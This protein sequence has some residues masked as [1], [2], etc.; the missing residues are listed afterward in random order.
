MQATAYVPARTTELG[1][2]FQDDWRI[3]SNLTA[4]MGVRYEYTGVPFGFFS[5]A[6][7]DKN[8][9]APR[10]GFAWK[11]G[12]TPILQ[13]PAR[14]NGVIRAGYAISYDQVFQNILLN[15]ARN[16]PRGV[17]V[18]LSN[19]NGQRLYD[20]ASRPAPPK[21]EDYT[22]NTALLPVRL[23]LTERGSDAALRSAIL[24]RYREADPERLGTSGLLRGHS[25]CSP[26]SR[27]RKQ[28]RLPE[29]CRRQE[30]VSLRLDHA[31]T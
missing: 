15:V 12:Q 19:M 21:P 7:P 26:G 6:T 23:V 8:N 13:V 18:A 4:N 30:P 5:N 3:T 31:S 16:Y 20:V 11:G 27:S 22:G 9:W 10:I 1:V 14:P 29:S 2:F 25:R 24:A 17:S 28:H